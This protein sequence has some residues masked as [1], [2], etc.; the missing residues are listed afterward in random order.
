[1]KAIFRQ[2]MDESGINRKTLAE[3]IERSYC[4]VKDATNDSEPQHFTTGDFPTINRVLK[5]IPIRE[6]ARSAGGVF[7]E[8]PRLVT[9][10]E[11]I[12]S[13]FLKAVSEVGEDSAAI[14]RAL[15]DREITDSEGQTLA[16]ELD[17]TIA[18]LVAVKLAVLAKAGK[19]VAARMTMP[20]ATVDQ[21]RR[22]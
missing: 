4:Y 6:L 7:V 10:A 15:S 19:P 2:A 1:V 14:E 16:A 21:R 3:A 5:N 17:D 11:D 22:A 18:A 8:L 9:G 13:T 12:Y 20:A